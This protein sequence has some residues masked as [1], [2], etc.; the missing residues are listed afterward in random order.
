MLISMCGNS[1]AM[2]VGSCVS[3]VKIASA[4]APVVFLPL[5]L[6]SGFYANSN[7]L[8]VYVR[9][10]YNINPFAFA[11]NAI[12]HNE[13]DNQFNIFDPIDIFKPKT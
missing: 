10:I 3:N 7:L 9:W 13:F 5:I 11:Y 6:T 2:L 4:M 12:L 8:P 1:M